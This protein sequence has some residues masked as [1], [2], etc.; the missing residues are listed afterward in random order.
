MPPGGGNVRVLHKAAKEALD[1]HGRTD[2]VR[3]YEREDAGVAPHACKRAGRWWDIG[4]KGV[5]RGRR[6]LLPLQHY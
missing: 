5:G 4:G 3:C 2:L 6:S 1:V